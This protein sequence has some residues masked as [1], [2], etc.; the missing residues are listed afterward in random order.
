MAS[1]ASVS[2]SRVHSEYSL[3]TAVIGCTA[4]ARRSRSLVTSDR[5]R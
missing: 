3:C 1:M 4:Y 5:P 2:T